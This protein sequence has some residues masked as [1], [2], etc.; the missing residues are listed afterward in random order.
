M[1]FIIKS[2]ATVNTQSD[3]KIRKLYYTTNNYFEN[4]SFQS[5]LQMYFS[6]ISGLRFLA[7]GELTS[8]QVASWKKI[9]CTWIYMHKTAIN[10]LTK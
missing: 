7:F 3:S 6:F 8:Y 2:N 10:T 5:N 4:V 1:Y 9:Q